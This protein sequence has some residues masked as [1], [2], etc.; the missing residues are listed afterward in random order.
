MSEIKSAEFKSFLETSR[1]FAEENGTDEIYN[2]NR[3]CEH[4]LYILKYCERMLRQFEP[5]SGDEN[6]VRELRDKFRQK[7]W[8]LFS[9]DSFFRNNFE[10]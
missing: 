6:F 1:L 2:F 10:F 4:R 9:A 7:W 5:Y 8:E 3:N